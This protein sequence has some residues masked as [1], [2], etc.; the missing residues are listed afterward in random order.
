MNHVPDVGCKPADAF[1]MQVSSRYKFTIKRQGYWP[2]S[3]FRKSLAVIIIMGTVVRYE[4]TASLMT[5]RCVME[6]VMVICTRS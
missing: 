2:Y 6:K 5:N 3:S 4:T 1:G